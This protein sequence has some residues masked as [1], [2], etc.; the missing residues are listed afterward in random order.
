MHQYLIQWLDDEVEI[1]LADASVCLATA[2]VV[3]WEHP[4][5]TC[6]TGRDLSDFDFLSITKEGF[7]PTILKSNC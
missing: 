4:K 3:D 1:V 7:I 6:L 5:A 2:E